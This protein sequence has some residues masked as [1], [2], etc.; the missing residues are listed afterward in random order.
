MDHSK[1]SKFSCCDIVADYRVAVS[2]RE[3]NGILPDTDFPL[4]NSQIL[5]HIRQCCGHGCFLD[6][7]FEG[8]S[9][10]HI[11]CK[12]SRDCIF[13]LALLLDKNI[14]D[15]SLY[16][17]LWR[18]MSIL[19]KSLENRLVEASGDELHGVLPGLSP[20]DPDII[21]ELFSC[22]N[23]QAL[24][25]MLVSPSDE[26]VK[27]YLDI[28]D[29]GILIETGKELPIGITKLHEI[30]DTIMQ[31]KE[32]IIKSYNQRHFIEVLH[33]H[34]FVCINTKRLPWGATGK[35]TNTSF[36][37]MGY[38]HENNFPDRMLAEY[39]PLKYNM[40]AAGVFP[41]RP[42]FI[43]KTNGYITLEDFRDLMYALCDTQFPLYMDSG[44]P[45]TLQR[46]PSLKSAR[47]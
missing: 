20:L 2:C 1:E 4:D 18:C 39:V 6:D 43:G 40:L 10:E 44:L 23:N 3:Y 47:K 13:T 42:T 7:L 37:L 26:D 34:P 8:I 25:K 41:D 21:M 9:D 31:Q 27:F 19:K 17:S 16:D 30:A 29:L 33:I 45:I 11:F 22:V 14:H 32:R 38:H 35:S 36:E 15:N 12:E 28:Q 46:R 5:S 24:F